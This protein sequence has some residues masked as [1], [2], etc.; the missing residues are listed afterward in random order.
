MTTTTSSTTSTTLTTSA[1]RE[2]DDEG[3][4]EDE[5]ED[6]DEKAGVAVVADVTDVANVQPALF[7]TNEAAT[8]GGQPMPGRY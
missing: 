5:D 8:V 6:E 2:G 4:G 3:E 7:G 1:T